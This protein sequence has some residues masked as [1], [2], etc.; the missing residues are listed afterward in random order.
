MVKLKAPAAGT[1]GSRQ[2]KRG[3]GPGIEGLAGIACCYFAHN[4]EGMPERMCQ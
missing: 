3:F 4:R 2:A 1:I